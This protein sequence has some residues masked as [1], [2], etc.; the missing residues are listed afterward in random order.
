[1]D[2]VF[3]D[4]EGVGEVPCGIEGVFGFAWGEGIPAGVEG[5][6]EF[7]SLARGAVEAVFRLGGQE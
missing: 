7:V 2:F 1:M 6:A 3:V 4:G 5:F